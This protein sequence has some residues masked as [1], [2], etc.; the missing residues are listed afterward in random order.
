LGMWLFGL[1][2]LYLWIGSLVTLLASI[3]ITSF[4]IPNMLRKGTV[5][6]LIV[7]PIHRWVLLVYKYVG[8][9]TFVLLNT[10]VA[11]GGIWLALGLRSGIWANT[12]LLMIFV[13]TFFFAILY[14]VST[15]VA[16]MTRSAIATILLTCAAWF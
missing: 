16:V 1:A 3:I 9:L 12:F 7:K 13:Y 14:A 10:A 8:G 4:F 5:D 2:T 15:L 11:L 6:L